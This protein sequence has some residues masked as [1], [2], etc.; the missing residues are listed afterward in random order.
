MSEPEISAPE[1]A[2]KA[3]I[4]RSKASMMKAMRTSDGALTVWSSPAGTVR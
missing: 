3:M 2:V 1:T 4:S